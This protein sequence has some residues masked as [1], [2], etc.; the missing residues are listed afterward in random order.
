MIADDIFNKLS[1]DLRSYADSD[2][3]FGETIDLEG[4]KIVPVC[5]LSVGY[6]GGGGEGEGKD[7]KSKAGGKGHG[8]GAGGGLKI[9]PVAI[10]V[11]VDGEV[12]V[13]SIGGK[14]SKLQSLIDLIPE[15]LEKFKGSSPKSEEEKEEGEE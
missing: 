1:T 7:E 14:E 10:I 11:S 4:A 12:S 5:K 6:G 13:A 8:G 9:E 3:V 15:A 2:T